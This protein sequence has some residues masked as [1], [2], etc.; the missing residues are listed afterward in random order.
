MLNCAGCEVG[1]GCYHA[2]HVGLGSYGCVLVQIWARDSGL[3]NWEH[4]G[5][6]MY[7]PRALL[8]IPGCGTTFFFCVK[9]PPGS[10]ISSSYSPW[11]IRT[12]VFG[13]AAG[14]TAAAVRG[15]KIVTRA[16]KSQQYNVT[17]HSHDKQRLGLR[18]PHT[19]PSRLAARRPRWYP[20]RYTQSLNPP[21]KLTVSVHVTWPRSASK[22]K[23]TRVK[24][25]S[26]RVPF[27]V[28]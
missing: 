8:K 10:R 7:C 23:V 28:M 1:F 17:V 16:P 3:N 6:G 4:R 18:P 11:G 9:D 20:L 14:Y 19:Q 22:R 15:P 5:E 27:S 26:I 12:A 21:L 25:G 2:T 13:A 24:D